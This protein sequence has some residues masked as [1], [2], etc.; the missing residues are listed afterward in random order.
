[1]AVAMN[2]QD[3]LKLVLAMCD[4]GGERVKARLWG[5]PG[6]QGSPFG[7]AVEGPTPAPQRRFSNDGHIGK[8][9]VDFS[10][11]L[12]EGINY[13]TEPGSTTQL[14]RALSRAVRSRREGYRVP[15]VSHPHRVVIATLRR[16][17]C[18]ACRAGISTDLS[19]R[20]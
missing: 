3:M 5:E 2:H 6:A 10:G 1:M 8:F 14:A 7:V 15:R 19:N 13:V 12:Y 9:E 11:T 16:R 4:E 17:R 20:S 18:R